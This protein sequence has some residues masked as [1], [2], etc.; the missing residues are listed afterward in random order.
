MTT[1]R[2]A[3]SIDPNLKVSISSANLKKIH[4]D[5][6]FD[7][8]NMQQQLVSNGNIQLSDR[9]SKIFKENFLSLFI[10]KSNKTPVLTTEQSLS[11]DFESSQI[12]RMIFSTLKVAINVSNFQK[13]KEFKE[14]LEDLSE[15]STFPCL[16]YCLR[17]L[18]TELTKEFFKIDTR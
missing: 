13:Y 4:F 10:D 7:K 9:L 18:D 16:Y 5:I 1:E 15:E 6:Q 2:R 8:N 17:N 11:R 3:T 14:Y 12:Y